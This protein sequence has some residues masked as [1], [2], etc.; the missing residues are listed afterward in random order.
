[1]SSEFRHLIIAANYILQKV[2]KFAILIGVFSPISPKNIASG[3]LKSYI[4]V[5]QRPN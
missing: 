2:V 4:N 3:T 5:E 1:M